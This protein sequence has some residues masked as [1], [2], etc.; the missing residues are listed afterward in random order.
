MSHHSRLLLWL[1]LGLVLGGSL[2]S[3]CST[4]ER[5]NPLEDLRRDLTESDEGIVRAPVDKFDRWLAPDEF[6][7]SLTLMRLT[8]GL[9]GFLLLFAGYALYKFLV[10][11]GGFI[12]GAILGYGFGAEEGGRLLGVLLAL[13]G[14][15]LGGVLAW[16]LHMLAVF[17]I[18][19]FYGA[20]LLA[21]LIDWETWVLLL[22][23]VLGGILLLALFQLI[24]VLITAS[25]GAVLFGGLA[26]GA[27]D[28]VILI[29]F[30]VGVL[31]QYG[32]LASRKE[33]EEKKEKEK[34]KNAP[35]D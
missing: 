26:L 17:A 12:V 15:W 16:I 27:S 29:L 28:I 20:I 19:A 1:L 22:G 35:A 25:T 14:G 5:D 4:V 21:A 3:G 6:G 18:G 11:L 10:M 24:I 2:L 13:V 31:V 34:A 32:L 30:A 8:Q 7:L 23:G 33:E 9:V